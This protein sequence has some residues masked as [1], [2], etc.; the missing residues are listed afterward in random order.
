MR[1][2]TAAGSP[3]DDNPLAGGVICFATGT[4]IATP[5]SPRRI[6]DLA[7]GDRI[8]AKD[9]GAQEILWTGNRWMTSARLYAMLHLRPIRLRAGALG[10]DRADA[11]LLVTPQHRMPAKG[12]RALQR[13][14]SAGARQ[15]PR[16]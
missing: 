5:E 7:A 8:L 9:D 4:R 3:F 12:A 13:A 15:G 11:G 2:A 1:T 10:V 14:R 16:Q 6:E